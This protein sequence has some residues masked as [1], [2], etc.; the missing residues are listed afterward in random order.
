M[1]LA[2]TAPFTQGKRIGTLAIYIDDMSTPIIVFPINLSLAL[3][4]PE[5]EVYAV[6]MGIVCLCTLHSIT[7]VWHAGLYSFYGAILGKT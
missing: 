2:H 3:D 6:R 5:G 1:V 7:M 4:M